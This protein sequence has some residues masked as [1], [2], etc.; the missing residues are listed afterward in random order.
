M[1]PEAR[2]T[3]KLSRTQPRQGVGAE[4]KKTHFLYSST[5][6]RP[7]GHDP[8]DQNLQGWMPGRDSGQRPE[9][10]LAGSSGN[11]QAELET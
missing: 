11:P 5:Y 6:R 8:A 3:Q 1:A 10:G 4:G 9:R 2:M 7:G